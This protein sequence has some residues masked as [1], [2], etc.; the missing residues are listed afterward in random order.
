MEHDHNTDY[1]DFGFKSVKSKLKT[2]LV[3]DLFS[4]VSNQYDVMNDVMSFGLHRC[5]KKSFIEKLALKPNMKILD[6]AGGT[7]DIAIRIAKNKA[8]LAPQV[9]V[10]DLTYDMVCQGK[11]K[12]ANAGVLGIRWHIGNAEKLPYADASFDR[13][14]IAF[15][16]RNVTNKDAALNEMARVLKPGGTLSCLEFSPPEGVLKTFYD[17][18]SFKIIPWVGERIAKDREAYQYLVESIRQFP[19]PSILREMILNQGFSTCTYE[20]WTGGIVTL[21]QAS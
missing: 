4:R 19:E 17:L 20:K 1:T 5:W 16:L 15:G 7:G 18:Y 6:V 12:T 8:Y 2:G 3:S 11:D 10:C 21:H 13:V 14:T 9:T